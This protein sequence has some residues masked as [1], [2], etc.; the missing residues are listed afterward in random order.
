MAHKE[1]QF[2]DA[3]ISCQAVPVVDSLSEDEREI[4]PKL[5]RKLDT[6]IMP[7]AMLVYLLN[8]IDR[9]SGRPPSRTDLS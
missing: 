3:S 4:E 6:R 1:S 9:Y 8:Y 7:I 5:R 2:D